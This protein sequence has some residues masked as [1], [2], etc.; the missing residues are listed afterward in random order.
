MSREEQFDFYWKEIFDGL[1]YNPIEFN[2]Y[3]FDQSMSLPTKF[4]KLYDMF[5]LL[6]LNNQEVMDYLKEFIE[7]FDFK[8]ETT[9]K[10]ILVVWL[11]EGLLAD[12]VREAIN[13]EVI[14]AR[15]DIENESHLKLTNRLG[16]WENRSVRLEDDVKTEHYNIDW[17]VP[18]ETT[19]YTAIFDNL[20]VVA[21]NTKV[22]IYL[23][24]FK[25]YKCDRDYPS[26][27]FYGNGRLINSVTGKEIQISKTPDNIYQYSQGEMK[28][29]NLYGT[30]NN[31]V[32]QSLMANDVSQKP[33]ILGISP[34]NPELLST[35]NN[36]DNVVEYLSI[37]THKNFLEFNAS[38]VTYLS[39]GVIIPS[40]NESMDIPVGSI[41]DTRHIPFY[42]GLVKEVDYNT[43]K[44]TLFKGWYKTDSS[45]TLMTPPS[46]KGLTINRTTALW[47]ANWLIYLNGEHELNAC[48]MLEGGIIND[49]P[50]VDHV[51]GIDM[52]LMGE[53]G[54]NNA[55]QARGTKSKWKVGF[56]DGGSDV[57]FKAIEP[58]VGFYVNGAKGNGVLV[59]RTETAMRVIGK[60][61][62]KVIYATVDGEPFTV[63][64]RGVQN[65]V[66]FESHVINVNGAI[67]LNK[68]V[69]IVNEG[70]TRV[71]LDVAPKYNGLMI[72]ILS[73]NSTPFDIV[74]YINHDGTT[75]TGY[76]MNGKGKTIRLYCDGGVW[77]KMVD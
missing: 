66:G 43:K 69:Q 35:Y 61:N 39:D 25:T 14:E 53:Y 47:V 24:E 75:K 22:P 27:C 51:T 64:N 44:I 45:K 41:L 38:Q 32:M 49:Q 18:R 63:S 28:H 34:D 67:D 33:Q 5:K 12:V 72:E 6:A 8:L 70:V 17:Y 74:G 9:I 29:K 1:A 76:N 71:T 62:D 30:F 37:S 23:P 68:H 46:D 57:S 60:G 52:L 3:R 7:T 73:L 48:T 77:Y 58:N 40:L 54:G 20:I 65:K 2:V 10:D 36:R 31:A 4:N 19:N 59:E 11:D 55:F 50:F 56:H 15:E 13:E 42:S 16:K 26:N 21:V